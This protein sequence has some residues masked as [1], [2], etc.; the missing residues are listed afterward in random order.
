MNT[1]EHTLAVFNDMKIRRI[2]H[3]NEWWFSVVDVVCAID[4]SDARNYWKVLKHSL[5]E[6]G[7][8]A[9]TF[10][11]QLKIPASDGKKYKSVKRRHIRGS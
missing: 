5:I 11:N 6:E 9:V 1:K 4:S 2:W 8:Q 7:S 3:E 10:C